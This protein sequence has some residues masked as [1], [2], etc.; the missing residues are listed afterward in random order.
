MLRHKQV[1]FILKAELSHLIFIKKVITNPIYFLPLISFTLIVQP[2]QRM[3]VTVTKIQRVK[4]KHYS[5]EIIR[6]L[7]EQWKC[8]KNKNK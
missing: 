6:S 4:T 7:G 5:W 8:T 2:Q 1:G 3:D